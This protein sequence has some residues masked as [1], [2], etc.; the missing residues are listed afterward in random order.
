MRAERKAGELS[1]KLERSNPGKRKTDLGGAVPLKSKLFRDSAGGGAH[2][3]AG[4][5]GAMLFSRIHR[6]IAS[7][8]VMRFVW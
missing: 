6:A 5:A 4:G 3:A 1:A 8:R 7:S 2:A